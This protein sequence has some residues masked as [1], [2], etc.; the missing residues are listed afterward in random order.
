MADSHGPLAHHFDSLE[1]QYE[2]AR[3]GMWTFLITEVMMFGGLFLG[4]VVY[5]TKYPDLFVAGSHHLDITLGAFNTV[6]LIVSSLTMAMAVHAAQEGR[7]ARIIGYLWLTLLLGGT[8][9][10]VKVVEY[11]HKFHD[12][13]IPGAHFQWH[14][15]GDPVGPIQLFFGYYFL[16]TGL[17][18]VH[19]IIGAGLLLWLI[20]L[21]SKNRFSAEFF[22]PVE[23]VGLYWHFVDIVWIFLFPLLYLIGRHG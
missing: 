14:G 23:M 7:R 21:A 5:R 2:S 6:V 10:G 17:H 12:H 22:T 18:A 1:Q 8:F 11:S 3:L 20:R 19:M 16:M 13:L 4:Y 15:A 9:L